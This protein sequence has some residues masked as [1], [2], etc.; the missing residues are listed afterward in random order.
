[1]AIP[2][3]VPLAAILNSRIADNESPRPEDRVFVTYRFNDDVNA[4]INPAGLAQAD[5][6]SEV[7]GFEKTL[8]SGSASVGL[9]VPFVQLSGDSN[10]DHTDVGD[11]TL[12]LKY[13]LLDNPHTGNVLSTGLALTVPT[14]QGFHPGAGS[15]IHPVLLQPYV[16]YLWNWDRYFLHGFSSVQVPIDLRDVTVLANDFG[17]GCWLYRCPQG[18]RFVTAIVPTVELHVTT[19]LDHRGSESDPVGFPD[20]VDVMGGVRFSFFKRTSLGVAVGAPI[21]G[22]RLFDIEATAQLN[23]QF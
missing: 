21:T 13:A 4:V 6:H 2:V 5:L 17:V 23:I 16:G 20:L 12:I 14:G 7:I 9:R 18:N 10:T 19:P 1:V 11:V 3:R 8:L 15:E 22:P